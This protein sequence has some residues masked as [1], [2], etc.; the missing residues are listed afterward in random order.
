MENRQSDITLFLQNA[1]RIKSHNPENFSLKDVYMMLL[2]YDLDLDEFNQAYDNNYFSYFTE[3]YKGNKD[4]NITDDPS[5]SNYLLVSNILNHTNFINL[6]LNVANEKYFTVL[7]KL[8]SYLV[9]HPE[10]KHYSKISKYSRSDQI[11]LSFL[12]KDDLLKVAEYINSNDLISNYLRMTNPFMIKN[13]KNG[14]SFDFGL[15]FNYIISYLID[16]YLKNKYDAYDIKADDFAYFVR[17][18]Y[19]EIIDMESFSTY[20][21]FISSE[22]FANVSSDDVNKVLSNYLYI[23]EEFYRL[24]SDGSLD[25]CFKLYEYSNLDKESNER[26]KYLVSKNNLYMIKE[27]IDSYIKYA[28]AKYSNPDEISRRL[29]DFAKESISDP[30]Y[31]SRYITRE[32]N[33]RD[34]FKNISSDQIYQITNNDIYYYVDSIIKLNDYDFVS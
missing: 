13:N 1:Y 34:L 11:I 26:Y 32:H 30:N 16:K 12:K 10:I 27:I 2:S 9:E 24:F 7:S 14:V 18:F 3:F 8:I 28:Y 6:Y 20:K 25:L 5:D 22:L 21:D 17:K 33:F 4:I 19:N 15:N 29:S 31:A 23:F